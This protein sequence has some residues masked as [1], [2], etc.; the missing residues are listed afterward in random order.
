M[1]SSRP[2]ARLYG[3]GTS[4]PPQSLEQSRILGFMAASA[5]ASWGDDG[6]RAV[7]LLERLYAASG[8]ER[9]RSVLSDYAGTDP[10]GF[11]FFPQNPAL[12]PFPSTA[13]RM[14]AFERFSV[15]LAET[16]AREALA[17]A[18]FRASDV[19]HLVLTTCTGFFSPGPDVL[20]I[21]RL[22]LREDVERT[23][24]G[25]MGCYAGFTALRLA[26]GLLRG[27][28]AAVVLLVNVELCTLHFQK[29]L[30]PDFM[31]ANSLFADGGAAAVLAAPGARGR[32]LADLAAWHGRVVPE[33]RAQMSWR[34]GD[35]G[36]EMGLD[37]GVPKTI[38]ERAPGFVAELLEKAGLAR[39]EV[40]RWAPHPGGRRILE[41]LSDGL[42]WG[43]A[44]TAS[45]RAVLA[46]CGNM[47]SATI[48][49][50]LARELS[51]GAGALAAMGF[52]PGL[53]MEGAVFVPPA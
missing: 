9:R 46:D 19:T 31:V 24:V 22:G 47:S 38:R 43:D 4:L 8:I 5:R 29:R 35:T 17:Q 23:N 52:G 2:A 25:F 21:E 51:R 26:G 15:G 27:D 13:L 11:A 33:G 10:A 1:P 50:V 45:A 39:E 42:G 49:F 3:L 6:A 18:G 7:P 34:V 37:R 16:S 40:T 53:T 36:F 48:F 44:E 30:L 12:E 20:L 14:E 41:A 28:P 32:G